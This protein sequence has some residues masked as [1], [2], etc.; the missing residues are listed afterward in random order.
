M[1]TRP[2]PIAP[3]IVMV[4]A[5][6]ADLLASVACLLASAACLL[7]SAVRQSARHSRSVP[8]NACPSSIADFS[9]LHGRQD[10]FSSTHSL[11]NAFGIQPETPHGPHR[12]PSDTKSDLQ[13]L[14]R[15]CCISWP[16]GHSEADTAVTSMLSVLPRAD[17]ADSISAFIVDKTILEAAF[18]AR[19]AWGPL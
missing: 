16:T 12:V 8:V 17:I 18:A 15:S 19:A 14:Q 6:S 5:L 9:S 3:R 13:R 1:A 10:S 4:F 11:P 2:P 7:A